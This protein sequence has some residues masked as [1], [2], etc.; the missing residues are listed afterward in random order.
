MEP[1]AGVVSEGEADARDLNEAAEIAELTEAAESS[2]ISRQRLVPR[3]R[4]RKRLSPSR[5]RWLRRVSGGFVPSARALG[6]DAAFCSHCGM[7][8]GDSDGAEPMGADG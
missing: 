2:A 8:L 5:P 7:R 3:G 1:T 4:Y 6:S